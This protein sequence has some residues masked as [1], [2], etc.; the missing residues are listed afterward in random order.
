MSLY[1]PNIG[2][3]IPSSGTFE[4]DTFIAGAV[5]HP[6]LPIFPIL[7]DSEDTV[8]DW[9]ESPLNIPPRLCVC[10][11]YT[12]KWRVSASLSSGGA[13]L[14]VSNEIV[15]ADSEEGT[16]STSFRYGTTRVPDPL[17][18]EPGDTSIRLDLS[19]SEAGR[20]RFCW[21]TGKWFPA[22]SVIAQV[23]KSSESKNTLTAWGRVGSSGFSPYGTITLTIAGEDVQMY[24]SDTLNDLPLS[25]SITLEPLEVLLSE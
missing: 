1:M 9:I 6:V 25:G 22:I 17:F 11:D 21:S 24:E 2:S 4:R 14:S 16:W 10:S 12:R 7:V 13:S 20:S 19:F 15:E 5:A 18:F 3:I 23:L 8:G